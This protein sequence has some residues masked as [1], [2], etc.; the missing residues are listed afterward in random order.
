MSW[1]SVTKGQLLVAASQTVTLLHSPLENVSNL[2]EPV[3][4]L[5]TRPLL[6]T[7]WVSVPP[8]YKVEMPN[9]AAWME[10]F[11]LGRKFQPDVLPAAPAPHA[12]SSF[13]SLSKDR[14]LYWTFLETATNKWTTLQTTLGCAGDSQLIKADFAF[15]SYSSVKIACVSVSSPTTVLIFEAVVDWPSRALNIVHSS[16][17]K[18]T[19]P[20]PCANSASKFF[21]Q[22]RADSS[23]PMS[24]HSHLASLLHNPSFESLPQGA[25]SPSPLTPGVGFTPL[26]SSASSHHPNTATSSTPTNAQEDDPLQWSLYHDLEQDTASNHIEHMGFDPYDTNT[27]FLVWNQYQ[28]SRKATLNGGLSER[29]S[30]LQKWRCATHTVKVKCPPIDLSKFVSTGMQHPEMDTNRGSMPIEM[31]DQTH[32][33]GFNSVSDFDDMNL[34]PDMNGDYNDLWGFET[35]TDSNAATSHLQSSG[36]NS[37]MANGDNEDSFEPLM[38]NSR[39]T[40]LNFDGPNHSSS[41]GSTRQTHLITNVWECTARSLI[42]ASNSSIQGTPADKHSSSSLKVPPIS[43]G[44]ISTLPHFSSR[45]S[46]DCVTHLKCGKNVITMTLLSGSTLL[47]DMETLDIILDYCAPHVW[48]SPSGASPTSLANSPNTHSTTSSTAI[49]PTE[50]SND[51]HSSNPKKRAFYVMSPELPDHFDYLAPSPLTPAS[52]ML[53]A[54]GAPLIPSSSSMPDAKRPKLNELID[55][56]MSYATSYFAASNQRSVPR[57]APSASEGLILSS[58]FPVSTVYSPNQACVAILHSDMTI[59]VIHL[60]PLLRYRV[61]SLTSHELCTQVT[62][63][64]E[65]SIVRRITF[66]DILAMLLA[67]P[68]PS[69]ANQD[70]HLH[71]GVLILLARDIACVESKVGATSAGWLRQ[72]L[73][74]IKSGIFRS[75]PDMTFNFLRSQALLSLRRTVTQLENLYRC[76]PWLN[77][78]L[79][80][81]T[82]MD[83]PELKLIFSPT[84]DFTHDKSRVEKETGTMIMPHLPLRW[85]QAFTNW[86]LGNIASFQKKISAHRAAELAPTSN[87]LGVSAFISDEP[88]P[89]STS[90]MPTPSHAESPA[91]GSNLQTP[92]HQTPIPGQ[93]P[94]AHSTVFTPSGS[95]RGSSDSPRD[96]HTPHDRPQKSSGSSHSRVILAIPPWAS[97]MPIL[98]ENLEELLLIIP[99]SHVDVG[100]LWAVDVPLLNLLKEALLYFSVAIH[101]DRVHDTGKHYLKVFPEPSFSA[102]HTLLTNPIMNHFHSSN[103]Y[104]SEDW[105]N[106]TII[107]AFYGTKEIAAKPSGDAGPLDLLP[108]RLRFLELN[109]FPG[110]PMDPSSFP[111]RNGQTFLDSYSQ[112]RFSFWHSSLSSPST[113]ASVS[114][115]PDTISLSE[116]KGEYCRRCTYCNRLSSVARNS[117]DGAPFFTNSCPICEAPWMLIRNPHFSTKRAQAK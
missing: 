117:P 37:N 58:G 110:S 107:P 55:P 5:E 20:S 116:V 28:P 96:I 49:A 78:I 66:W 79:S 24:W 4:Q 87:N 83:H 70:Q 42:T 39:D 38:K 101:L 34:E 94:G 84:H 31:E 95:N 9:S 26:G 56:G 46:W 80:E 103:R 11:S 104:M 33:P 3:F 50:T 29:R 74:L 10:S 63:L 40:G 76:S 88:Y 108:S 14:T 113:S 30:Y 81:A 92:N 72:S 75:S 54:G 13:V 73:E 68:E 44:Q 36:G 22:S 53:S 85:L 93:T 109:F 69:P 112:D 43:N 57:Q 97:Q 1:S 48:S 64:L 90:G 106:S 41:S 45:I 19:V 32:N 18:F 100:L 6:L 65:L 52:N 91:I 15:A 86:V 7:R 25:A 115:A 82:S 67:L 61:A 99:D 51:A 105:V 102:C 2:V 59:R 111:V 23:S 47:L 8:K 60:A 62:N 89:V 77:K 27:L 21:L 17:S 12:K 114:L 16:T 71:R 35:K 98:P